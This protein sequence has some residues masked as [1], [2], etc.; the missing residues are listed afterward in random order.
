MPE[1]VEEIQA[2]R[3]ITLERP[4]DGVALV[5]WHH[6]EL[7]NHGTCA[8][9]EQLAAALKVAREGGA[10]VCVL[11]SAT[12][13]HWFQHAWLPDLLAMFRGEPTTG[14][15]IGFFTSVAE[16]THPDM[17]SIAAM[18]GDAN[19]GG[20]E[21]GW[22][23]DLRVAEE[24]IAVG[25]P[26]IQIGLTT[27][28][29][30]T[31]RLARLVGRAAA[32]EMILDGRPLSASRLHAIGAV[33]RVVATGRATEAALEWAAHIARQSPAA[34]SVMKRLL[35]ESASLPLDE[36]LALEQKRFQENART[37]A[38][39]AGMDRIQARFDAGEAIR[40]VYGE[41]VTGEPVMDSREEQD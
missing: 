32:A 30:G 33:N 26:E 41:P 2:R 9:V 19:G 31:V 12:P 23:C 10:R 21:L 1:S 38:A 25:Q 11:A 29:G 22:A 7:R 20:A 3:V 13:G 39:L 37:E 40:S 17:I 18:S 6:P 14:S 24:Q 4:G 5:T 15:G 34:L 36:A 16:L 8:G 28:L 35:D 27:G